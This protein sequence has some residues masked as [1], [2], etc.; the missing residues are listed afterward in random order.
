MSDVLLLNPPEVLSDLPPLGL[1]YVA[2]VLEENKYDVNLIDCGIEKKSWD[3]LKDIVKNEQPKIVG[4]TATTPGISKTMKTAQLVK[5]VDSNIKVALGGPH[6]TILPSECLKNKDID[7]AV[8]GEGE[9]AFLNLV[10]YML[11]DKINLKKI[12]N[13][14]FKSNGKIVHNPQSSRI[15]DLDSLPW[16][17]RHFVPI[18][19][20]PGVV[21]PR[22]HPETQVMATR[23]CPFN[24]TFCSSKNVFGSTIR[25]RDPIKVVDEIEYLVNT[26]KIKTINFYD[27]GLNYKLDW[28]TKMCN[29]I[30]DRGLN[31]E[32]EWKAQVRVNKPFV[33][34]ELLRKMKEA[35][36]WLLCWGIESGDPKILKNIKKAITLEEARRAIKMCSAV[37][38]RSLG[39]FMAGNQGETIETVERTIDFCVELGDLGLDYPQLTLAVPYPG[40]ELFEVCKKN[41]W[42]KAK[43]WNGY[44]NDKRS[45][46]VQMPGLP[47]E[48]LEKAISIFYKRFYFRPSYLLK[49]LFKIRK[50]DDFILLKIGI[51]Y[52]KNAISKRVP[53][54]D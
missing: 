8:R 51:E 19:K 34:E 24:C 43:T 16:P 47:D 20:Y 42:L 23:G 48:Y 30:I 46:I 12:Q 2:A 32:I 36:C 7:F 33:T 50:I 40:T 31:N 15:D 4:I 17:A 18:E 13:L 39:Y 25:F 54:V 1:L 41:N 14:S 45:V 11:R 6:A 44:E 38:I 5:K 29:E 22:K 26:Y 52:L 49:Q 3:E 37:G 9:F 53:V 21:L 28:T 27:D 10:R 35:G